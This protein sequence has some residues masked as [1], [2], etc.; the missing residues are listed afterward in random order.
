MHVHFIHTSIPPSVHPSIYPSILWVLF[1]QAVWP[2]LQ[3]A[4]PLLDLARLRSNKLSGLSS[5]GLH[6]SWDWGPLHLIHLNLYV[7]SEHEPAAP[8]LVRWDN[9]VWMTERKGF[10]AGK[11]GGAARVTERRWR[12]G[13]VEG[14]WEGRQGD[15][16]WMGWESW[17]GVEGR[18]VGRV[19]RGLRGGGGCGV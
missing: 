13:R 18:R 4:A 10:W 2:V 8:W 3:R 15:E 14:D 16:G 5:N 12:G 19:G 17:K 7:G 1:K 6:Y 9:G 11:G